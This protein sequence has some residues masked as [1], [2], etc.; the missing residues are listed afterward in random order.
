MNRT[1]LERMRQQSIQNRYKEL[2]GAALYQQRDRPRQSDV[3][4]E[5]INVDKLGNLMDKEDEQSRDLDPDE[6]IY[7]A[8]VVNRPPAYGGN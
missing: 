4:I 1:D 2:N 8:N 6:D 5:H 7:D 3:P